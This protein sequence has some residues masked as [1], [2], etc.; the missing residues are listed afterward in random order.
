MQAGAALD[1]RRRPKASAGFFQFPGN[2]LREVGVGLRFPGC[3]G[4]VRNRRDPLP[5]PN[6]KGKLMSTSTRR[7]SKLALAGAISLAFLTAAVILSVVLSGRRVAPSTSPNRDTVS[8]A[9][10]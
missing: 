5:E 4:A 10:F 7:R 9:T 1:D 2:S 6:P 3:P 8:K